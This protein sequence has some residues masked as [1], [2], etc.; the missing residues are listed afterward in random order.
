MILGDYIILGFCAKYLFFVKKISVGYFTNTKN[1]TTGK[2]RPIN[3]QENPT[4]SVFVINTEE[5]NIKQVYDANGYLDNL[6]LDLINNY[7]FPVDKATIFYIFDRDVKSNTDSALIRDL[8]QKLGNSR[9]NDDFN[10]AGLLLLSYPAIE[11]FTISNFKDECFKL[12]YELGSEIKAYLNKNNLSNQRINEKSLA[13]AAFEM[14]LALDDIGIKSW[15]LDYFKDVNKKIFEYQELYY[16]N[17]S[18]YK[19]LSLLCFAFIDLGLI[20]LEE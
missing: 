5:S 1:H 15:D 4:S 17:N 8:I 18:V 6:F 11:S 16:S 7:N 9:D 14:F 20:E 13:K 19:V 2:Y 12:E 3:K 10:Q